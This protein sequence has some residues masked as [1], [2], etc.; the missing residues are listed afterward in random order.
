M[1]LI[2][3]DAN[4][5]SLLIMYDG[6][7]TKLFKIRKKEVYKSSLCTYSYIHTRNTYIHLVSSS[8]FF[9]EKKNEYIASIN[10]KIQP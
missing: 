10:I 5:D 7:T 4:N 2:F 6:L 1:G 9:F 3:F 8:S